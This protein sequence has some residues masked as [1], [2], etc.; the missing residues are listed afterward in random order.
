MKTGDNLDWAK[1]EF[2][3]RGW[4][5]IRIGT[6]W[7]E[8]GYL[9]YDGF[10]WYRVRFDIPKEWHMLILGD[11]EKDNGFLVLSLGRVDDVDVTYFNGIKIGAT[12]IMPPD[13]ASA[14]LMKRKYRIPVSIVNWG[15]SNIIAVRVYDDNGP[16]GIYEGP[17]VVELPQMEDIIEPSFQLGSSNGI[18][19]SSGSLPVNLKI[20]NHS[21]REYRL[22]LECTLKSDRVDDD[23]AVQSFRTE[24]QMDRNADVYEVMKCDPPGPGFYRVICMLSDSKIPPF[25][26]S[27]IFGYDP[28]K[29]KPKLTHEK[30][31]E[32]FWNKR[33]SDME[34]IKPRFDVIRSDL[35]TDDLDVYLVE[36]YSYGNVRIKGWY[37]V[38]RKPGP[39]PAILSLP[40]Y[41][42]A[43]Q[44]YFH[45]KNVA[46]LALNP[47][48]HGNSKED[49]DAKG[50]EYMY[51]G[52]NPKCPEEY[53]YVG[54][55]MD[56]VR[57]VDFLASRP[58]IDPSRIGVEGE[59]Q[60]GGLSF[61]TAAL[62]QRIAFCASDIPWLGDWIGYLAASDWPR[63]HYPELI[64]RFPGLTIGDINRVLSYVDTMNL[65]DRIQ[66]PVLMS[67]GL[68]DSVC[69]PRNAFAT[70]NRV[71]SQKEYRIYP[72]A[73]HAV[74][75]EHNSIKNA[76]I[77][78]IFGI[79]QL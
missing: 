53:V 66:C 71:R 15:G 26:K 22:I 65:A 24:I 75:Q 36:M 16:G 57:A 79:K 28:E 12:G 30:D 5:N 55:Y 10:A 21:S 63:K 35:S 56:C 29:I 50:G 59:S 60:G 27:M 8:A 25:G 72:L 48:G 77:A 17:V 19:S 23:S 42:I 7:E 49:V 51:L 2:E 9:G 31:F 47:R 41:N 13:Y 18:Y 45:R 44:P 74:G 6:V 4:T 68:Q 67:V 46:T 32:D 14:Y 76:W 64:E 70:Y 54:A 52:F 62:D 33:K 40:G 73:D 38:P 43:M 20:S 39:H 58:E 37:T 69:P 1:P 34:K 78:T 61:A 3:H 11:E